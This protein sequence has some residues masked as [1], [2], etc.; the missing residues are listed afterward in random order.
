MYDFKDFVSNVRD[1][2]SNRYPDVNVSVK[3][4][5]KN[6]DVTMT[7]VEMKRQDMIQS[8]SIYMD[9]FYS[10]YRAGVGFED[11]VNAITDKY[12]ESLNK[13]VD[14]SEDVLD[15]LSN[16][17]VKLINKDA[18]K[19][20]LE[21]ALYMVYNDLAITI[22]CLI[23]KDEEVA[24]T[25]VK[26][27]F[28]DKLGISKEELFNIAK[29]NTKRLFPPVIKK[30]SDFISGMYSEDYAIP[31][32]GIYV[33]TNDCYING[34][35]VMLY[36]DVIRDFVKEH[37]EYYVIP[38]SVH[39]L[40]LLPKKDFENDIRGLSEFVKQVNSI[41]VP[42]Q[43]FLSNNIYIANEK[44]ISLINGMGKEDYMGI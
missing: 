16:Y 15:N 24:S 4:V 3:D 40:M 34:A 20:Y 14:I 12:E 38:S 44:G 11:V 28:L 27:V 10:R 8:P 9:Y 13:A 29:E 6:N 1:E 23:R 22:R 31:D 43:D 41:A 21:G 5:L 33:V 36:D 7:A 30:M 32:N 35:T 42:K 2:L 39:E 37:G 18:N 25:M 26:D 19:K 17:F